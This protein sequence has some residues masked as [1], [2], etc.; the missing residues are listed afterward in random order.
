MTPRTF[1]QGFTWGAATASY[2]IEGAVAE[3]GRTPSI[4]DTFS[5]TPGAITDGSSGAI[6]CDSYHR[7]GADTQLLAELGLTAYRFSIAWPRI[8]PA[9]GGPVNQRGLDYYSRLIDGL[10]ERGIAPVVTLYHWDLPQYLEDAGG[11]P[12]RETAYHYADYVEVVVKAL[13]DR[14][15]TWTTLNEPWCSAYLGYADGEHAPG[16]HD[17][18]AALAAAH[19]L[20]L[21]HGLGIQAIRGLRGDT[22]RTSVTLNLQVL[23]P[24][25]D[26]E[27][28]Q[29]AVRQL[30]RVG[31]DVWLLPMLEGRY[32]EQLFADTAHVSDWSFVHDGDLADIQ[33]PLSVLGINYYSTGTVRRIPGAVAPT[34]AEAALTPWVGPWPGSETIEFLP[35]TGPLT[36]MGWNQDPNG[37]K[38]ILLQIHQRYPD[39]ELMVTENGSAWDDTVS[40]DGLVH[41]PQRVAYFAAHLEALGQAIDAGAPITAYFAWS[42]LDNFEWAH[43]YTKRFGLFWT[44]YATQDRV[45]KDSARWYQ[46]LATTNQLPEEGFLS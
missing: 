11:W 2:Q 5:A 36:A 40:A 14:V 16:Y 1:P 13:G 28:D 30:E 9:P 20:N 7:C 25:S 10:L 34:K 17:A 37:L 27:A 42:L 4:W 19:H 8:I 22:A 15:H 18:P 35:P 23:R 32:D 44:D 46:R 26:S 41:D 3:D 39:L 24:A 31:N 43:G 29:G 12:N 21:A 38:D 33:Q 45:W 6:A